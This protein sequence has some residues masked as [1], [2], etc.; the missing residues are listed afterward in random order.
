MRKGI[1][2]AS[3]ESVYPISDYKTAIEAAGKPRLGKILFKPAE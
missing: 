1:V 3:V 2:K